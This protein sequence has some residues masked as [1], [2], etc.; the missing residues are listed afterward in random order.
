ML[1]AEFSH[2]IELASTLQELAEV[3][4]EFIE[5]RKEFEQLGLIR[6]PKRGDEE[7]RNAVKGAITD[8]LSGAREILFDV[9]WDVA[10]EG[11]DAA[12]MEGLKKVTW[13]IAKEYLEKEYGKFSREAAV[14]IKDR[15][16]KGVLYAA[17]AAAE[18]LAKSFSDR[19]GFLRETFLRMRR[20]GLVLDKKL[21]NQ[22]SKLFATQLKRFADWITGTAKLLSAP[23]AVFVKVFFTSSMVVDNAGELYLG[24]K[25]TQEH[26]ATRLQ[27]LAP[28]V[29]S[30]NISIEPLQPLPNSP[31][32][33]P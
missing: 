15:S 10:H 32:L 18:A 12:I 13:E 27:E 7:V 26:L 8:Q 24:F 14:A 11:I 20:N 29:P 9:G 2:R 23:V 22:L 19:D 5:V 6:A 33:M 30:T 1:I 4:D 25:E 3:A 17:G 16:L 21:E 31:K 28:S